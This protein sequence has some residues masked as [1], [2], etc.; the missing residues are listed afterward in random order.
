MLL[1]YT[2]KYPKSNY[3]QFHLVDLIYVYLLLTIIS[4]LWNRTLLL[5]TK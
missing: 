4:N 1:D 2:K 3:F 5:L